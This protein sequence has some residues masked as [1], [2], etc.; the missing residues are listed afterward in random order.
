MRA[1]HQTDLQAESAGL[2]AIALSRWRNWARGLII[3]CGFL[4]V[5][6]SRFYVEP[7]G[8]NYLDIARAYL[9]HNWAQAVNG[10]WSPLYSWL[11]AGLIWATNVSS[12]WEIPLLHLLNFAGFCISLWC[13]EFFLRALIARRRETG[14]SESE[15]EAIPEGAWWALGYT[16]FTYSS[17]FLTPVV[18]DTPDIFVNAFVFA[19][20]GLVIKFGE[21]AGAWRRSLLLGAILGFAY[22]AKTVMFPLGFVFLGAAYLSARGR[23]GA[24]GM[25]LLAGAVFLAVSLPW[26]A[27][28]SRAENR[29]TFGDSGKITYWSYSHDATSTYHWHG[30]FPGDGVPVHPIKKIFSQP[31]VDSFTDPI[32][33]SYPLLYNPS[34]WFE[35][36]KSNLSMKRQLSVFRQ[37]LPVYFELLSAEKELLTGLV[38]LIF[39][40]ADWR[41]YL[42]ELAHLACVWAPGLAALVLYSLVHVESRLVGGFVVV[43]WCS[44]YAAIRIRPDTV[45]RRV[46]SCV[47]AAVCFVMAIS[48]A[49]GGIGYLVDGLRPQTNIQWKVGAGLTEMG[50]QRGDL[51]AVMGSANEANYW[52][53]SGQVRIVA[54][55]QTKAVDE[56][57]A[58]SAETKA[59]VY[60]AIR[61]T[62]AKVIVTNTESKFGM[63]AGWRNIDAT[64]Y[65]VFFLDDTA[66]NGSEPRRLEK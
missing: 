10:Y 22:L 36:A 34:Y 17:L 3:F 2:P 41:K 7:D 56:F 30:E 42:V 44:L 53:H 33:G 64:G 23:K 20:L 35:G 45:S 48:I 52:A 25:T 26:I 12:Y 40:S 1:G 9:R 57:W 24:M 49:R 28:L 37:T 65:S 58:A 32:G 39:F 54:D 55:I 31:T 19:A 4:Q 5:W 38:V 29:L 60:A 14:N 61:G 21:A 27:V 16:L 8:V 50:I 59:R 46:A 66:A 13:F 18:M 63:A 6:A 11:L 62:G 51:V 15:G 47:T 43:M